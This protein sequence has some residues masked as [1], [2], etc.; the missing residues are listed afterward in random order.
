MSDKISTGK[1]TDSEGK[2]AECICIQL[3]DKQTESIMIKSDRIYVNYDKV[4]Y[5]ES[6]EIIKEDTQRFAYQI[7]GDDKDE[8]LNS[9]LVNGSSIFSGMKE[10]IIKSIKQMQNIG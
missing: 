3:Q 4:Y 1:Y 8:I 10:K 2:T 9:V 6:G 5:N 7:K